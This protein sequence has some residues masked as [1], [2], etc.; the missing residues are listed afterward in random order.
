MM[1]V[2]G[3]NHKKGIT[4]FTEWV[5]ADA[6][7]KGFLDKIDQRRLFGFMKDGRQYFSKKDILS[8]IEQHL[9]ENQWK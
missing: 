7:K 1:A 2:S 3:Y 5:L 6:L 8:A 9:T 4:L